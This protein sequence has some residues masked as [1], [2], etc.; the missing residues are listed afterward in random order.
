MRFHAVTPDD[1][2]TT[3]ILAERKGHWKDLWGW[4][5][6]TA[7]ADACLRGLTAPESSFPNG[8]EAFFVIAP[9]T[10][11]QTPSEEL[12]ATKYPELVGKMDLEGKGNIGFISTAKIE[13]MLGWKEVISNS[14]V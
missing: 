11:Q 5:S 10:M 9:T 1:Q 13:K 7:T 3:E 4:V 12:L 2:C 14:S 6:L 8:H